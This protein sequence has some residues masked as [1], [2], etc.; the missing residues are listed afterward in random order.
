[1]DKKQKKERTLKDFVDIL[2]PK[3]WIVVL[4]AVVC[5][6]AA[7]TFSFTKKD[8]YTSSAKYLV[9]FNPGGTTT[10]VS[11]LYYENT[12]IETTLNKYQSIATSDEF[13]TKVVD[14][15]NSDEE[16]GI[17]INFAQ[18]KSMFSFSVNATNQTFSFSVTS[19]DKNMSFNIA[20]IVE[21]ELIKELE[22]NFTTEK[23]ERLSS[24]GLPQSPNSKHSMRNA[25]IAFAIGAILSAA[26]ILII[27]LSDVTIR[28]KKKIE[29]NFNIPILGVIPYHDINDDSGSNTYSGRYT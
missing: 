27:A 9:N 1:M 19:T 4:T 18:F 5:A 8:M 28:D 2:L 14:K 22:Q 16:S 15:I 7:F 24:P 13:I 12:I 21:D 20:R 6:M 11:G 10:N 17:S 26:V 25:L 29:D 23:R 3:L